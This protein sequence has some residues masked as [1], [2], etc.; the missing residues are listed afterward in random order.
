MVPGSI[1]ERKSGLCPILPCPEVWRPMV[2]D[3]ED[4]M[5]RGKYLGWLP[6]PE[7]LH[8]KS[9]TVPSWRMSLI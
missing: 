4:K 3:Q 9:G 5:G 8:K 7:S 6:S 1:Q 2:S